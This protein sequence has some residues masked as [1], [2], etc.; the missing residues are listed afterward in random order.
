MRRRVAMMRPLPVCLILILTL[1]TVPASAHNKSISFSDWQWSGKSLTVQFTVPLRD[2]TLLPRRDNVLQTTLA[3]HLTR[4][5]S[6]RQSNECPLVAPFERVAARKGYMKMQAQFECFTTDTPILLTNHAFFNLARSHVHF[7]RVQISTPNTSGGQDASQT[8]EILFTATQ[9]QQIMSINAS[10][11]ASGK[12]Q[13]R[14]AASNTLANYFSLGVTHIMTGVDHL[15]FLFGLTL[16]AASRRQALWLITG[17]T[18]GH[19]LTLALAALGLV[20]PDARL[21]EAMIGA[22]IVIVASEYILARNGLMPCAGLIAVPVLFLMAGWSLISQTAI[23]QTVINQTGIETGI[24]A[25][26]GLSGW[27]GLMLFCLCYGLAIER[28]EDAQKFAPV[29]TI[30]FGLFHGFGFAGLLGDVGLPTGQLVTGLMGFN[31]GVEAGQL[32]I[33]VPLIIFGPMIFGKL[34][35]PPVSWADMVACGLTG[36]GVFIFT[37]RTLF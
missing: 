12:L 11:N 3:A 35:T 28:K 14:T 21:V 16:L 34:P 37:Q 17:F 22:S 24:E 30:A 4:H 2:V 8:Q 6:L 7:A 18:L 27:A 23:S 25:G 1:L 15:A 9:R 13:N 31:L 36:F 33:F 26:I 20:N 29:M 5:I 19:S 32:L 10:E